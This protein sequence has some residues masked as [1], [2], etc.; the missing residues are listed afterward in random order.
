MCLLGSSTS[1]TCFGR[2][3]QVPRII[4]RQLQFIPSAGSCI[5]YNVLLLLSFIPQGESGAIVA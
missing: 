3:N 2:C 1:E 4:L 5:R